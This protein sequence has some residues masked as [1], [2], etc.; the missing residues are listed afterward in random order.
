MFINNK[1]TK[2]PA[3][4]SNSDSMASYA[5]GFISLIEN[6]G[7]DPKIIFEKANIPFHK[8]SDPL[9]RYSETEISRLFEET[10]KL[11]D[12][13]YIGFAVGESLQPGSLHALGFGLMAS[14][15]LRDFFE[16][17]QNYFCM[18]SQAA[19]FGY[20]EQ[21]SECVLYAENVH[22]DVCSHSEDAWAAMILK[23]LRFLFQKDIKPN[24]V[25]FRHTCST[26]NTEVYLKYFS[27]PVDF[28]CQKISLSFDRD[29]LDQ[30]FNGAN[31]EMASYND[32]ISMQFIDKLEQGNIIN[33]VSKAIVDMLKFDTP[34]R[35]NIS[36]AL[37]ITEQNLKLKLAAKDTCFQDILEDIRQKLSMVY[38]EQSSLNISQMAYMLGFSDSSNFTRAFKR[39]TGQSPRDYRKDRE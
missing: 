24:K 20:L 6:K 2:V 25:E 4:E 34:S 3:Y 39:W 21:E 28:G 31:A 13:P 12:D 17:I 5:M 1:L 16:R 29:L 10:S 8:T 7:V 37:N 33:Q 18:A 14:T 27:C 15:S 22:P 35:E 38:I 11:L 9:K 30:K 26:L 23:Y 19:N 32:Q 36:N